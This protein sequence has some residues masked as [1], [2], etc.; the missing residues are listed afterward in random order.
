MHGIDSSLKLPAH[1]V[2]EA[3]EQKHLNTSQ[4][5]PVSSSHRICWNE[6][7][8]IIAVHR[9][10]EKM[11]DG[12]LP[13]LQKHLDLQNHVYNLPHMFFEIQEPNGSPIWVILV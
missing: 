7:P 8:P 3:A 10:G 5:C 9:C 11:N 2:W 1:W 12:V 6:S 13:R 4:V